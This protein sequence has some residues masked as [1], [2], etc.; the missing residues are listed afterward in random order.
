MDTTAAPTINH[1]NNEKLVG[2]VKSLIQTRIFRGPQRAGYGP[3]SLF[4]AYTNP[5]SKGQREPII[6][7][8]C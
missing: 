7:A 3:L 1:W 5:V 8:A 2:W 4:P 6:S